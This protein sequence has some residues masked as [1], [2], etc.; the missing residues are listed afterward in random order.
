[1][2]PG[3][4]GPFGSRTFPRRP[5][6]PSGFRW[7]APNPISFDIRSGPSLVLGLDFRDSEGFLVSRLRSRFSILPFSLELLWS[8]FT[9]SAFRATSSLLAVF[10]VTRWFRVEFHLHATWHV[11]AI[12]KN[13]T[14]FLTRLTPYF[15]S[16]VKVLFHTGNACGVPRVPLRFLRLAPKSSP[17]S[18]PLPSRH[19]KAPFQLAR[20]TMT[21]MSFNF[22][23]SSDGSSRSHHLNPL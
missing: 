19:P 15:P 1:M 2:S 18:T 9:F 3:S 16:R 22:S 12:P 20:V 5:S 17:L 21:S 7:E 4:P 8:P 13:S 23:K 14:G 6:G 10:T 11:S